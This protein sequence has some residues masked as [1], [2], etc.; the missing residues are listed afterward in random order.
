[1]VVTGPRPNHHSLVET[2]LTLSAYSLARD[3]HH[4]RIYTNTQ[5][6]RLSNDKQHNIHDYCM[7]SSMHILSIYCLKLKPF[8]L[9]PPLAQTMDVHSELQSE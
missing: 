5:R 2:E 3:S 7:L 9:I 6:K 8:T 4:T 1:M